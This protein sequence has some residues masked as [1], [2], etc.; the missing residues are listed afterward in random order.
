MRDSVGDTCG[1]REGGRE[2]GIYGAREGGIYGAREGGIYGASEGGRYIWSER[3]REGGR[4]RKN[5]KEESKLFHLASV[6]SETSEK[7]L[8]IKDSTYWIII[9]R[10][11]LTF[12]VPN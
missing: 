5:G 11:T 10:M 12:N 4:E 2:G 3:G 9:G 1:A 7:R 8:H 6:Y